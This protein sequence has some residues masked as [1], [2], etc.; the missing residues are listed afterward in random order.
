MATQGIVSIKKSG[1]ML[2]K[3]IT[4]SDGYNASKLANW[5]NANKESLSVKTLHA[6]ALDIGFGNE[7]NLVVQGQDNS[8]YC[9]TDEEDLN[10]LYHD[11]DKFLDPRFNP[12]WKHGTAD[13]V[14]IVEI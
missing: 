10:D 6:A 4:G 12:R 2:F 1:K 11:Q 7:I 14:E 13:F 9:S 3:V 5:V 8:L